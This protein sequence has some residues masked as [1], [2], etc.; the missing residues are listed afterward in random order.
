MAVEGPCYTVINDVDES[1]APTEASLR[2]ELGEHCSNA[3]PPFLSQELTLVEKGDIK[4][5]ISALKKVI[6]LL[7]QGERMPS[8]LMVSFIHILIDCNT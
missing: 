5:K 6:L 4:V 7:Q 3:F 8:L 1:E 2:T